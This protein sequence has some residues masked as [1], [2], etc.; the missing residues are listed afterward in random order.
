MPPRMVTA[1]IPLPQ[2]YNPDR[3]GKRKPVAY[4]KFALTAEEI[5]QKFRGGATLFVFRNGEMRGFWWDRGFVDK[6]VNVLLVVDMP[7]TTESRAELKSYAK[8]V[9]LRRFRQKAIYITFVGPVGTLLV[10]DEEV[11]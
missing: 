3:H 10:T 7:D 6:D 9:L 11:K 4:E 1:L 8:D 2:F 5:A